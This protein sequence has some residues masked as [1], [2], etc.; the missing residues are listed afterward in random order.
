MEEDS[1]CVYVFFCL[2]VQRTHVQAH[3]N[4]S[5]LQI[6]RRACTHAHT[7]CVWL[8]VR[9]RSRVFVCGHVQAAEEK[10]VMA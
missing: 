1:A 9:V 7:P 6:C 2:H 5:Q 4:L 8:C 3:A 10:W